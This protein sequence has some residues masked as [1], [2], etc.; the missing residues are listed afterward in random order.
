[1]KILVALVLLTFRNTDFSLAQ[2]LQ[3]GFYAST[4][5]DAESIVNSIVI[6]EASSDPTMAPA[7]LRLHFHDCF[8]Q[9]CDGSILILGPD[10]ENMSSNHQGLRG[11]EVID[12][13][14]A[15]LE[16]ACPGI[17]SCADILAMVARDSV[18]FS[19][20]PK[21]S[22]ETG[23]RD[24][25]SSDSSA[26]VNLPVADDSV[27]VLKNKFLEK[28][29]SDKDLVLLTGAH[30]IGTTACFF[31]TGRLYDPSGPDPTINPT[32]LP[33]L[34]SRCPEGGQNNVRLSL[35][36]DSD[37]TFDTSLYSNIR[38][39]FGV[40]KSDAVL[41]SDP[42]TRGIIDEYI[43]SST[44]TVGPV[45]EQDFA[46]SMVRMGRLGEGSAGEIRRLSPETL[47]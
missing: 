16:A 37:Q 12:R 5:P 39:G 38:G 17:V 20:G 35:D 23:R 42:S 6:K 13:V 8:V 31:V 21:Y 18:A 45:F 9:G 4:C 11:F 46:E 26:A 43:A 7:L 33:E 14:K 27:S 15:Q 29:L 41:Y 44:S 36:H 47:K 30:T 24:G 1:M 22:V 25:G 40:I 2:Q 28:G 10:A 19:G 3:Q 32:I 34:K